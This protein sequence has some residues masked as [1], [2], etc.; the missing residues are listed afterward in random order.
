MPFSQKV[1]T[2]LWTI[3]DSMALHPDLFVRDPGKD[4]SRER[5]LG[6]VQM[7]RLC[8]CMESGCI[9]H[10]L[11]K[12]FF[13]NPDEAPS[14]SAFVQQRAK[15]L[16][17]AFY[18]LLRQFNLQFMTKPFMG[19][20]S[21][22]A[23]DGSEFN[24]ARDPDDKTTFH[25][26]SGKSK[27]GFNMLHTVS[28]FELFSK[29][30]LDVAVQPGREKNEFAAMCSLV[31][32]YP[33]GGCP[34]FVADRGFASYNV[35]AHVLEKGFYFAIR[36]KDINTKRL[37]GSASLPGT[38]DQ[39]ADV[40]LTR[41][42][43]KKKRKHPGLGSMYRYICR[44]VPFDFITDAMPEY[45]MRLRVV[46]FQIKEGIYENII[47]NLPGREFPAGQIRYIYQLRWGIETSFRD[48][49][50]TIGTTNFHSRSPEYIEYEVVCRMILYNF[51]TVITMEVKPEKKEQKKWGYQVNLSMAIKICFAFLQDRVAPGN[52]DGLIS[53]Y[54]L[55]IRPDR[56]YARQLRFQL[57]ASFAYRFV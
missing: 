32:R 20:Y 26:S 11:L 19:R 5:K 18:H 44:A 42:N 39:W 16:P 33:Y 13:F 43:A 10:E 40:I 56:T 30:Y 6:F 21:L 35:F 38:T 47:T 50:H 22:V 45:H 54:M 37:L 46:R 34:I 15:L 36:A 51:S 41:S 52:V 24:I 7:I 4:F 49:K 31:D 25:P 12:Y 1:K 9:S 3:V 27:K 28:L 2:A 14:A 8:I 57:P 17:E 55:P 23:V 48:L 29:R 53:Q